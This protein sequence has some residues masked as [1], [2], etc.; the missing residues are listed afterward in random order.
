MDAAR[1]GFHFWAVAQARGLRAWVPGVQT[2]RDASTTATVSGLTP[3]M[4]RSPRIGIVH[5]ANQRVSSQSVSG[6]FLRRSPCKKF[7]LRCTV[8]PPLSEL[9]STLLS[10]RARGAQ[11]MTG[12]RSRSPYLS[13]L[14]ILLVLLAP[15]A[16]SVLPG[17]GAD[18]L[19]DKHAK[20]GVDCAGCHRRCP[21]RALP[22]RPCATDATATYRRS[23]RGPRNFRTIPTIPIGP[24][25][26]ATP[27]T[28]Y[29]SRPRTAV[30]RAISSASESH[31]PASAVET[32]PRKK[33]AGS[34]IRRSWCFARAA[35]WSSE[36]TRA[37]PARRTRLHQAGLSPATRS[38][39]YLAAGGT[40]AARRG[41]ARVPP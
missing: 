31:S 34:G 38:R 3:L 22:V 16:L 12:E 29:I 24:T 11:P 8:P 20:A 7:S 39:A 13:I 37:S 14:L 32:W 21:P 40:R 5:S 23:P 4:D 25:L 9:Q 41:A 36:T 6:T 30:H 28:I 2:T 33:S 26:T 10:T 27:A 18:L 35:S 19:A 1:G 15:L 17:V